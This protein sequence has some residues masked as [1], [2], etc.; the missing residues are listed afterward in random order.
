ML[1]SVRVLSR[2][3]KGQHMIDSQFDFRTIDGNR[4]KVVSMQTQAVKVHKNFVHFKYSLRV[5][6]KNI[7]GENS[8]FF[9]PST[10]NYLHLASTE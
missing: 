2:E 9:K 1:L 7:L 8:S 5:D 10:W 3:L 6:E 4:Y